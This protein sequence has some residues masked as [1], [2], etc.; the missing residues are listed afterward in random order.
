M[1]CRA[2][3]LPF[4]P[5][6]AQHPRPRL[7]HPS[8]RPGR[9]PTPG[10]ARRDHRQPGRGRRRCEPRQLRRVSPPNR[11]LTTRPAAGSLSITSPQ[12]IPR[13]SRRRAGLGQSPYQPR[14]AP[15]CPAM[16]PDRH[17]R[18]P[19]PAP[20]RSAPAPRGSRPLDRA[21]AGVSAHFSAD[22]THK[23][24]GQRHEPSSDHRGLATQVRACWRGRGRNGGVGSPG[25]RQCRRATGPI[26]QVGHTEHLSRRPSSPGLS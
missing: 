6:R 12:D 17:C 11:P 2:A 5:G 18:H 21:R 16:P 3:D 22:G 23:R 25:L 9:T 15:P 19:A 8:H 4:L 10:D 7:Q 1:T 13:T 24:A 20:R 14:P 26:G